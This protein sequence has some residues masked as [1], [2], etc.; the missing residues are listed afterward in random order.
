VFQHL[1]SGHLRNV[2]QCTASRQVCWAKSARKGTVS[3]AFGGQSAVVHQCLLY[4]SWRNTK[5]NR[6]QSPID[7]FLK[8]NNR[9]EPSFGDALNQMPQENVPEERTN[10][11]G[12]SVKLAMLQ[13]K[14]L[15]NNAGE[16][17]QLLANEPCNSFYLFDD[18]EN[19]RGSVMY[20]QASL[21]N[22]GC[23]PNC[24]AVAR[25]RFLDVVSI[26]GIAAGVEL[27]YN[28]LRSFEDGPKETLEPWGFLCNCPR[29]EG[30]VSEADLFQFDCKHRCECGKIVVA[31]KRT[32]A[33]ER[34]MCQCHSQNVCIASCSGS[35]SLHIPLPLYPSPS[36]F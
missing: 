30:T 3:M 22:H 12:Q 33:N 10:F 16:A 8:L 15:V 13:A 2:Q 7:R 6:L 9:K 1:F 34:F 5:R 23:Y 24:T 27:T 31:G 18:K 25:G 29:C 11:C 26:T 4:I 14:K 36:I 17:L 32:A 21:I 35:S 19:I 28:Y 20:P